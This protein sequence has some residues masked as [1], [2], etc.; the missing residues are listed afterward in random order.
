MSKTNK[1]RKNSTYESVNAFYEG[2]E[3][4]L[5]AFKVKHF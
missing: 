1:E 3:S 2:R 4:T 5:N